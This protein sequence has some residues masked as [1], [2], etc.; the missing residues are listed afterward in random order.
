[1]RMLLRDLSPGQEYAI[2]FRSNNGDGLTSEWS[3]VQRFTTTNDTTRPGGVQNLTWYASGKSFIAQWDK[4]TIDENNQP[5]R[6]LNHYRCNISD[7]TAGLD[8]IVKDG[9]RL[10][11]TEDENIAAF[12]V[13]KSQLTLKVWAVDNTFNESLVPAMLSF[14]PLNPPTPWHPTVSM[15]MGSLMVE[16]NGLDSSPMPMPDNF[17]YCEVHVSTVSNF[18]PTDD[19]FRARITDTGYREPTANEGRKWVQSA[20]RVVITS[21]ID[22]GQE[23][24]IRLIAVNRLNRRSGP[25]A[26]AGP[27]VVTRLTGL[28]IQNG[29]ISKDQINFTAK[30]IGG[31]NAFYSTSQPTSG[32]VTGDLWYDTDNGYTVYRYT[33]VNWVVAPEVG[34]ISGTKILTGT[35]TADAVGTNLL[36]AHTANIANAVIDD[37]H[38]T[39]ISAAKITTGSIQA[40]QRVIAGPELENHAE[41]TSTGFYVKGPS[42][43]SPGDDGIVDLV[44]RIRMGTGVSDFFAIPDPN[45]PDETLAQIDEKGFASFQGLNVEGDP[46]IS[47]RRLISDRL[48]EVGGKM[49]GRGSMNITGL[50]P[51]GNAGIRSEYGIGQFRFPV[52]AGNAYMIKSRLNYWYVNYGGEPRSIWRVQQDLRSPADITNNVG[53]ATPV[54]NSSPAIYDRTWSPMNNGWANNGETI[55]YYYPNFTGWVSIGL[56]MW[57]NAPPAAESVIKVGNNALLTFEALEVGK[58]P[59]ANSRIHNQGGTPYAYVQ[60]PPPPPPPVVNYYGE[61]RADWVRSYKGGGAYMTNTDGRA[62]QGYNSYNG[63]QTAHYGFQNV[64]FPAILSG[65]RVDRVVV[66]LYYAHWWYN[67]GGIAVIGTHNN[68]GDPGGASAGGGWYNRARVGGWPKPGGQ[69]VDISWSG[70]EWQN[71]GTRGIAL[72]PGDGTN[73]TFYGYA[74][75]CVLKIWYT[76]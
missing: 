73:L 65:A 12:G 38:I 63:N 52:E 41:M 26:Q 9:E 44:D 24:Y 62:Y 54:T 32:M 11:F 53:T 2:Q 7:G 33:G 55:F 67:S 10:V 70:G 3:Q 6:D 14:S 8:I 20:A 34:V 43:D 69:D 58:A 4:V 27:I 16:W 48:K 49:V 47:G 46:M 22:Y 51:A 36:I 39:T 21:G 30:D 59:Q 5:L 66:Y 56:S 37:A 29:A 71:G 57:L 19:T 15:Y 76:R 72:G 28:D 23:Y 75:D 60:P 74:T 17:N 31:A 50:E 25:S 18:T 42:P 40:D 35:L 1:M 68:W 64:N 45:K 61:W 13:F